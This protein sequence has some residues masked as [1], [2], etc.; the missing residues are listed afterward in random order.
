MLLSLIHILVVSLRI[1]KDAVIDTFAEHQHARDGMERI[2]LQIW[3]M[4]F[5][6]VVIC[7]RIE[8]EIIELR[9]GEFH[10]AGDITARR[11]DF[12]LLASELRINQY[13]H[14]LLYTSRCV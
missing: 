9:I 14:C 3:K 6:K 4:L 8:L 11:L 10:D 7:K 2:C 12:L 5:D 13:R 1:D